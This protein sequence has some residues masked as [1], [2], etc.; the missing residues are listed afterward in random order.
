MSLPSGMMGREVRGIPVSISTKQ[1]SDLSPDKQTAKV[2]NLQE[3]SKTKVSPL[4]TVVGPGRNGKVVESHP[5]RV[6]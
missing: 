2:L 1:M 5:H 4:H 6:Y 3:S